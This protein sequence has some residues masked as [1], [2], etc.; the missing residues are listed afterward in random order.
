ML[1]SN[2]F[3]FFTNSKWHLYQYRVDFEPDEERTFVRKGMLRMHRNAIGP[4]IFD[5]TLLYTSTYIA[6]VSLSIQF[7]S[8]YKQ[9]Y[10]QNFINIYEKFQK[11]EYITKRQS[12]DALVKIII[13]LVG[14][15]SSDD[16]CNN[17]F[18]NI[19]IRKCLEHLDLQ[20]VGR[21][22][23]DA[24]NKVSKKIYMD[25]LLNWIF[26]NFYNNNDCAFYRVA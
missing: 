8:P 2:H 3:K 13:C 18:F 5:G 6:D 21:D 7:I 4:Y 20:L 15:L 1:R 11:L 14:Q 17:F 19:I 24:R 16:P 25:I 22:Y 9:I 23:Y 10:T 26:Y 12:D